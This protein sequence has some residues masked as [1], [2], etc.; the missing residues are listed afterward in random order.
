M[1]DLLS[2]TSWEQAISEELTKLQALGSQGYAEFTPRKK[3]VGRKRVFTVKY[4]PTGL[5]DRY[6]ARLVAKGFNQVLGDDY[7]ETF[8]SKIRAESLRTLLTLGAAK[9]L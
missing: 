8:P 4:T 6:K 2:K 1:A 7:L 5:I 9:D 3:P